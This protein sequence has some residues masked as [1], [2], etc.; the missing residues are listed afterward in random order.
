MS[1]TQIFLLSSISKDAGAIFFYLHISM[2]HASQ[3]VPN[4]NKNISKTHRTLI[5][6]ARVGKRATTYKFSE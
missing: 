3:R 5:P 4:F 2:V 1:K 6:R